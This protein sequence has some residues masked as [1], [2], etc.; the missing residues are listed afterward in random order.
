MC[1][2]H[3]AD[4][5]K[6]DKSQRRHACQEYAE[7]N[8][9]RY[10]QSPKT[11][12]CSL[13]TVTYP[14]ILPLT[15]FPTVCDG[16]DRRQGKATKKPAQKKAAITQQACLSN[17]QHVVGNLSDRKTAIDI[18]DSSVRHQEDH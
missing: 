7:R 17:F 15:F 10:Q 12:A 18:S 1:P 9:S 6:N 13:E 14:N 16:G 11:F 8:D 4:N 2:A 3:Y 5:S